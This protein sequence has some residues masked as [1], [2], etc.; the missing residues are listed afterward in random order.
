MSCF[1][2]SFR[3]LPLFVIIGVSCI[4][5]GQLSNI[6]GVYYVSPDITSMLQ[7]VVPVWTFIVAAIARVEKLPNIRRFNGILKLLGVL[8][9]IGGAFMLTFGKQKQ[10]KSNKVED[11]NESEAFLIFGYLCILYNTLSMA[12]LAVLQKKY[13]FNNVDSR[14]K[15]SPFN[16][17]A[18]SY[19]FGFLSMAL[20]SLYYCKQPEKFL[21]VNNSA[22][23]VLIYA[24]F[25]TSA[26]NYILITW[27]ITKI[28]ATLV[29]AFWPLQVLFCVILANFTIGETLNILEICGGILTIFSLLAVVWSNYREEK[30]RVVIVNKV[31]DEEKEPLLPSS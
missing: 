13:I 26:L 11:R 10:H 18:W 28:S 16:V 20:S 2:F 14:W 17:V 23:Y 1:L 21:S 12:L 29:T 24:V 9:A 4:F 27:I 22:I 3:E 30:E 31:Y 7:P 15:S 5:L 6:L 19:F 25:V 8:L